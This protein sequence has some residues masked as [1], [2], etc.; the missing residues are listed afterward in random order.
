VRTRRIWNQHNYHVT[1]VNEDGTIPPIEGKNWETPGL[2]NFRQ[3]VQPVATR[4]AADLIVTSVGTKVLSCPGTTIEAN[5][6]NVGDAGAPAGLL[7]SF[8]EGPLPMPTFIGSTPLATSILPGESVI[9]TLDWA[10]PPDRT[11][12]ELLFHAAADDDGTAEP[13]L[14]M[15]VSSECDETNNVSDPHMAFCPGID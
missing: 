2:N 3:N 15:Q 7:V 13:G 12:G 8:F 5:V 11:D 10:V 6:R 1:N 4:A 14:G 9:V